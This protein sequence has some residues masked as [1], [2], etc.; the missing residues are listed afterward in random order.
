MTARQKL[1]IC[2]Y[3]LEGVNSFSTVLFFNYLYFFLAQEFGFGD[4]RNFAVAAG[5]G[6]TY[7]FGS[8]QGGRFA[9]RSGYFRAL[10]TGYLVMMAGLVG[11]FFI[12]G[13]MGKIVG[14]A[15]VTLG[16][17]CIW[18]TIEALVT[19]GE[20]AAGLPRAVG[21][22]NVT[23]AVANAV[24]YFVG[25]TL[26]EQFG[27]RI[28]F[29]LPVALTLAQLGAVF[30]LQRHA[31]EMA[32]EAVSKP[33][34][35]PPPEPHRPASSR[36]SAFLRMAWL[37]NPFAYIAVNTLIAAMPG[38]A[39]KFHLSPMFAGFI[40]TMWCFVRVGAFVGLWKWTG[41]HYRFRWLAVAFLALIGSFAAILLSPSLA[42][43]IIGQIIF[44]L[45]IGLI[46][47]SS[48]FYSMDAGDTKSEHGGIHEAAIGVGNCVGPALGALSLQFM[49]A[50]PNSGAMAVSLLLLCG[51][52]GL[53]GIWKWAK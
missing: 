6:F 18:P 42:V 35:A 13:A 48:L 29:L 1:K 27:Y 10:K 28:I 14:S 9:Q 17:C 40:C 12:P 44:G 45:A 21:I 31:T 33:S 50:S 39:A 4:K 26:I 51:F 5:L 24:S 8:W 16:M 52:G 46:Y 37:A 20:S 22:Y 19:D 53:L 43:F 2:C 30:W 38:I 36:A 15:V 49:P 3:S 11:A 32:R 34:D 47:Y 41:W 23:W 25:G 7:I